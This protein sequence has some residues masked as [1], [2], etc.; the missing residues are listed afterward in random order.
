MKKILALIVFAFLI[1]SSNTLALEQYTRYSSLQTG[2]ALVATGYVFFDGIT[3][4][5]D[6]TNEITADIHDGTSVSGNKIV[7]TITFPQ[8]ASNKTQAYGVSPGVRCTTGIYVNVTTT[9]TV[10]YTVYWHR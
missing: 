6:G 5:G 2:D 9:G 1:L 7:P 4:T 10:S 8:S 3:V